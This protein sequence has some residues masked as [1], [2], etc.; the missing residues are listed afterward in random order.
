MAV[1]ELATNAVKYGAL[2]NTTG[3]VT[4]SWRLKREPGPCSLWLEWQ[5]TG[6]PLVKPPARKGF[7]STLIERALRQEQGHSSFEF[8]PEGV[9]CT[10]EMKL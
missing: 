5:E 6:G 10:L 9:R 7:G 8:C 2:S 1:H 4:L 3:T